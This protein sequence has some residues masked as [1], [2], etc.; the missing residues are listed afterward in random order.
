MKKPKPKPHGGPRPRAGRKPQYGERREHKITIRVTH[1]ESATLDAIAENRNQ[2]VPDYI[3]SLVAS[4]LPQPG[5][6][7][8]Q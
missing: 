8:K 1:D 4:S 5:V 2:S 3:Y 7:T 6:S